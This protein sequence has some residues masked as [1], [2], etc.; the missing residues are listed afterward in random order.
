MW[1][2]DGYAIGMDDRR[3]S[4]IAFMNCLP[5]KRGR[6]IN[7]GGSRWG[8]K[9]SIYATMR[10][11][12]FHRVEAWEVC[13]TSLRPNAR[14]PCGGVG[15][16]DRFA[17]ILNHERVIWSLSERMQAFYWKRAVSAH[18]GYHQPHW[19]DLG[20]S[21]CV[22]GKIAQR[23]SWTQV[24]ETTWPSRETDDVRQ[25]HSRRHC[26]YHL[27]CRFRSGLP[28]SIRRAHDNV[29]LRTHLHIGPFHVYAH[30]R[31][32]RSNLHRPLCV[33]RNLEGLQR[34]RSLHIWQST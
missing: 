1:D 30:F 15:F 31:H 21:S 11:W 33:W 28:R 8:G 27:P 20:F 3:C 6:A 29:N 16:A 18:L 23:D 5:T 34:L 2:V 9:T 10:F 17:V 7:G 32:R 24:E 13:D 22:A 26:W 14:G 12:L 4:V 25:G 19:I